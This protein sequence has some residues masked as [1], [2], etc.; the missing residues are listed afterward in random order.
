[1]VSCGPCAADRRAREYGH[2]LS[3]AVGLT[4]LI[5][6]GYRQ[7]I[8]TRVIPEKMWRMPAIMAIIGLV[9]IAKPRRRSR[10]LSARVPPAAPAA[11]RAAR[12]EQPLHL[13]NSASRGAQN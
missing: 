1:M 12:A 6:I 5:W 7:L 10:R 8:W 11:T 2:L 9:V 13:T 4:L 3:I